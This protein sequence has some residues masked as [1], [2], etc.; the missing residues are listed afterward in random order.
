[1]FYCLLSL[2]LGCT[3]GLGLGLDLGNMAMLT[4]LMIPLYILNVFPHYL[5]KYLAAFSFA[6]ANGPV[7]FAPLCNV[8]LLG[9]PVE[10]GITC[11]VICMMRLLFR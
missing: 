5:V 4:S 8:H 10:M 9:L 11:D 3:V 6:V 2:N 7:V 1:L